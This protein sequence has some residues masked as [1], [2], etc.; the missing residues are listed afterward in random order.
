VRGV[1]AIETGVGVS[2]KRVLIVGGGPAGMTAAIALAR[3]SVDVELVEL[4][5]D[6]R[7]AGVGLLLQSPPLRALRTIGLLDAC[8]EAGFT[9]HEVRFCD[10]AGNVLFV[11]EPPLIEGEQLPAVGIARPALHEIL[12]AALND[13]SVSARVGTTVSALED[14]GESVAVVFSDGSDSEYD[15]VVGADGVNSSIRN[16]VFPEADDPI[17]F[18]Q[19][20]WR[21][22][23]PRP[24]ELRHYPIMTGPGGKLGLVPIS[25]SE[26]YVWLL[27]NGRIEQRPPTEELMPMMREVMGGYN[28]LVDQVSETLSGVDFRN[29]SAILVPPPWHR[30]RVLLIGDAA[31]TTTPHL[32]F[33]VGMAIEDGIVLAEQVGQQLPVPEMLEAFTA[34]RYSRCRLVVESSLQLGEWEQHPTPESD[35]ARLTREAFAVLAQPI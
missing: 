7:P 6:W 22:A 14:R 15:L 30:G 34:R 13:L 12:A 27:Q 3:L 29:L 4:D 21:A 23:A 19:R 33:G 16:L 31:H 24:V 11:V 17:A 32:A 2:V 18:G 5:P 25:E 28:G 35:P 8:I 1:P 10:A 20:I 26:I 9:H